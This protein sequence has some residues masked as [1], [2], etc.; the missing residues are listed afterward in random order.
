MK[1]NPAEVE[2]S[3]SETYAEFG[4]GLRY[5]DI[6]LEVVAKAKDHIMDTIGCGLAG[7]T[8]EWA[9]ITMG[10]AKHLGGTPE[11]TIIRDGAQVAA[12]SAALA[13]GAACSSL[14]YDDTGY[15]VGAVHS[16]RILVPTALAVAEAMGRSG[17]DLIKSTIVGWEIAN[18]IGIAQGVDR[19]RRYE[20]SAYYKIMKRPEVGGEHFAA[21]AVA[22]LLMGLDRDQISSS[23]AFVSPLYGG[24]RAYSQSHREGGDSVPFACGWAAHAGVMAAIAAQ[25]GLVG[26]RLIFE[27]DKGFF[28]QL[29]LGELYAPEKLTEELERRWYTLGNCIK[30]YPAGH[31]I[32]HF[33]ESLKTVMNEHKVRPDNV[34]EV[35]CHVPQNRVVLHFEFLEQKLNPTPYS[36]RFSLPFIL[37]SVLIDGDWNVTSS[38]GG[39]VKDRQRLE[40]A[41]RVHYSFE[42]DSWLED[43]RGSITVRSKDGKSYKA[44]HPYLLGLPSNTPS[45]QQIVDKFR[46]NASLVLSNNATNKL[47]NSL[48]N[49]ENVKNIAELMRMTC[50]SM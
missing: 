6:P 36:S 44:K 46:Y 21:A 40:L 41:K 19:E 49:L 9:Q 1:R 2:K 47:L 30:F 16:S 26:P 31:G 43:N 29:E 20:L 13:C 27:G 42:E 17:K 10:M 5:E 18:R 39:K 12:P 24:K 14:D 15:W 33:I 50:P 38:I 28:N 23:I 45:H 7:S 22:A 8:M 4:L 3:I 35:I 25:K 48:E 32:H 34:E 11:A 37:A